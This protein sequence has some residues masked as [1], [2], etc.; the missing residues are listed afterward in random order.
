MLR[1]MFPDRFDFRTVKIE[2]GVTLFFSDP[3]SR[4]L[5]AETGGEKHLVDIREAG[6]VAP[7]AEVGKRD[8]GKPQSSFSFFVTSAGIGKGGNLGGL[9]GADRHC[10]AL[11]EAAGSGEK[12]WRAYL[13]TSYRGRQA[14]NGGDRIGSGPWYNVKEIMIARGVADLHGGQNN[15]NAQ[16]ALTEKGEVP[17]RRG[18]L[19]GS[20]S[21]GTA[22]VDMNCKN[23]T[24]NRGGNAMV[25]YSE[26]DGRGGNRSSWNSTQ[27]LRSCS[28]QDFLF[29]CFATA[30]AQAPEV[31]NDGDQN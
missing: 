6:Y 19:T 11:A 27:S 8:E 2:G 22:A 30:P 26:S 31:P 7:V 24:S 15:V 18:I 3:D 13:S 20:L 4:F 9:A 17:S 28:E 1:A 12:T 21:D 16:T 23:W 10:Q 25:V 14:I 5:V 29:Y